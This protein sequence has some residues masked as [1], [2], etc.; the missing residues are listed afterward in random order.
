MKKL[1]GL[2]IISLFLA[3]PLFASAG[4]LELSDVELT[5]KGTGSGTFWFAG[6]GTLSG[7][8]MDYKVSVNDGKWLEAFCVE[9]KYSGPADSLYDV[10][11]IDATDT[12]NLI[13]AAW[14][15]EKYYISDKQSAQIAIW[16]TVLGSNF[17]IID[18]GTG[19]TALEVANILADAALNAKLVSG[20]HYAVNPTAS[21]RDTK[22]DYQNFIYRSVPEPTQ[23]LLLGTA[24]IGLAGIG[25]KKFFKK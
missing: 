24:L 7:V 10:Y 16:E 15:A 19:G 2:L 22:T 25:R 3:V 14:I 20:W 11:S 21:E 4:S 17:S 8:E 23:M 13:T 12:A 1:I 5:V 6:L 9:N 18:Y